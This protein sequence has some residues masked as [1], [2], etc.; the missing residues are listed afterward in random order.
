[1][2]RIEEC[3]PYILCIRPAD[4]LND[5]NYTIRLYHKDSKEVVMAVDSDP[6]VKVYGTFFTDHPSPESFLPTF[7]GMCWWWCVDYCPFFVIYN[8]RLVCRWGGER[9]TKQLPYERFEHGDKLQ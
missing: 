7:F 9:V 3:G 2:D 4:F 1:M 6:P 8:G 5:Y